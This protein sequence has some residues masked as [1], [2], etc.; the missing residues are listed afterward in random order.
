MKT[1]S[2]PSPRAR[3]AFTIIE[4][5]VVVSIIAILAALLLPAVAAGSRHA[6]VKK[7]QLE[8]AA[9]VQAIQS[10][11]STYSRYPVSSNAL[12][13]ATQNNEDFTY[14]TYGVTN[15]SGTALPHANA[16]V[17]YYAN[18]S[19]VI[20]ILMDLQNFMD[21][22]HTPT[23]NAGHV[24]NPQQIKFLD[25]KMP[26]NTTLPGV[27]TDL[28]Y[29]D[30]WG[31]PYIISMDLNYDG[32][33]RDDLYRLKAVSQKPDSSGVQTG[34]VGFNGLYNSTDAGGN[35]NTFEY[36]G[37]VMVWS[38][39][40]DSTFALNVQAGVGVNQDNIVSWK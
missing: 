24:R 40:P 29:R 13:S 11:Y 39:G 9:L 3:V 10:Y 23:V 38:M 22:S 36:N 37:G 32:K 17:L 35:G 12:Y 20:A 14:G 33:C 2:W 18:N 28:V 21:A 15:Y 8:E 1:S 16:N 27:G 30:P 34:P 7:A 26:G 5:L 25:A 31:N 6:R 19:E 4:L